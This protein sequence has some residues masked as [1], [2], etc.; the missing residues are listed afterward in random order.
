MERCYA[1]LKRVHMAW[2]EK[3]LKEQR[4]RWKGTFVNG[5]IEQRVL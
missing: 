1:V 3:G 2:S 4:V 5:W